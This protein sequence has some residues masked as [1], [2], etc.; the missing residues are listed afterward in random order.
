[1]EPVRYVAIVLKPRAP[2]LSREVLP[3]RLPPAQHTGVVLR[4]MVLHGLAWIGAVA[5]VAYAY[6][7]VAWF[8][9]CGVPW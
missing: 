5:V 6:R 3:M 2:R 9:G 8:F 7:S 4:W 1:M